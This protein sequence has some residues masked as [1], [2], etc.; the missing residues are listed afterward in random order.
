MWGLCIR[1]SSPD[2]PGG[3]GGPRAPTAPWG[4][5]TRTFLDHEDKKSFCNNG[6]TWLSLTE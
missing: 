6:V 4:K 3:P 1:T 2:L 5:K